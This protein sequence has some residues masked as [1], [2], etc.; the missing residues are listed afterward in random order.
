[1]TAEKWGACW[2]PGQEALVVADV[3]AQ[4]DQILLAVHQPPFLRSMPVRAART[5]ARGRGAEPRRDPRAVARPTVDSEPREHTL[6]LPIIGRA[7][8]REVAPDQVA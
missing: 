5:S 3:A 4:S 6:V 8:N 1:M 7:G 2:G